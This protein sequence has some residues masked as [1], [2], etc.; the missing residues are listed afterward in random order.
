MPPASGT[1]QQDKSLPSRSG[2]RRAALTH[3]HFAR[4]CAAALPDASQ[5]TDNAPGRTHARAG[6][7]PVNGHLFLPNYGHLFCRVAGGDLTRRL[8]GRSHGR[9]QPDRR[10]LTR[11]GWAAGVR[12]SESRDGRGGRTDATC[13]AHVGRRCWLGRR[14]SGVPQ[15]PGR[16]SVLL[17]RSVLRS[18]FSLA[19]NGESGRVR[20]RDLAR[21]SD[22]FGGAIG[23]AALLSSAAL[24]GPSRCSSAARCSTLSG[25]CAMP[26]SARWLSAMPATSSDSSSRSRAAEGLS[27]AEQVPHELLQL[28]VGQRP[29]QRA[30]I[31]LERVRWPPIVDG[32]VPNTSVDSIQ[33]IRVYRRSDRNHFIHPRGGLVAQPRGQECLRLA[34]QRACQEGRVIALR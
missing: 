11:V 15:S 21:A 5:F 9:R 32:Q 20:P 18:S 1:R 27:H 23:P 19:G 17:C 7:P 16:P 30:C 34:G 14:R 12:D 6:N 10:R 33:G 24:V 3:A 28:A 22:A 4:S 2:S 25:S 29:L 8:P 26:I 13:H 31:G